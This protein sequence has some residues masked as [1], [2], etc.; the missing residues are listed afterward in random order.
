MCTTINTYV[1]YVKY[2]V[3]I[4]IVTIQFF[5]RTA[6]EKFEKSPAPVFHSPRPM[7]QQQ[8]AATPT[9]PVTSIPGTSTGPALLPQ[10]LQFGTPS[11][12]PSE[13]P[14][15]NNSSQLMPQLEAIKL[16]RGHGCPHKTLQPLHMMTFPLVHSNVIL[17]STLKLRKHKNGGTKKLT[18]SSASEHWQKECERVS[19]F[20]H[21]KKK[22]QKEKGDDS[23]DSNWAKELSR[24]R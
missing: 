3:Y 14:T 7:H 4:K 20:Y 17:T 8:A 5:Y 2:I 11:S 12:I 22:L 23:D 10:Q 16:G 21:E 6:K 18:S 19:K 9:T 24:I 1:K 15:F 13:S